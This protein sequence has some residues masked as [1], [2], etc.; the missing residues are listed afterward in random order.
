[1]WI[2]FQRSK[3]PKNVVTIRM[4]PNE[5]PLTSQL[6]LAL[7]ITDG[8]KQEELRLPTRLPGVAT[9]AKPPVMMEAQTI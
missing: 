2:V 5:H 9:M 6:T 7:V 3:A 4:R 8:K 1:M